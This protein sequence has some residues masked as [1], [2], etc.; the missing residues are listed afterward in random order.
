MSKTL[1]VSYDGWLAIKGHD[2]HSFRRRASARLTRNK[3]SLSKDE[4]AVK[5]QIE[6]PVSLFVTP[7]MTARICVNEGDASPPSIDL[8][9]MDDIQNVLRDR[10]GLNITLSQDLADE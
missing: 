7:A 1:T 8:E 5:L 6:L 9:I 4:V 2:V 10:T 3:P